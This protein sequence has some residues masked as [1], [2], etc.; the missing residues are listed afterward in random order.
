MEI[1]LLLPSIQGFV[2][3]FLILLI[4]L[5]LWK[6]WRIIPL[7]QGTSLFTIYFFFMLAGSF[8]L[9]LLL[10]F[11]RLT[12]TMINLFLEALFWILFYGLLSAKIKQAE[13]ASLLLGFGLTKS[14]ALFLFHSSLAWQVY[15][16][17]DQISLSFWDTWLQH[18]GGIPLLASLMEFLLWPL[19][20]LSLGRIFHTLKIDSFLSFC[21]ALLLPLVILKGIEGLVPLGWERWLVFFF[22]LSIWLSQKG[23]L[24]KEGLESS[25]SLMEKESMH[26][27]N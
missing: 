25:L 26:H 10:P 2:M 12:S 9:T 15:L 20:F 17:P 21:F 3:G 23:F 16:Y 18:Q 24:E 4:F 8:G 14:L 6:S 1:F 11:S 22:P 7:I 5:I 19:F 27:P 13:W